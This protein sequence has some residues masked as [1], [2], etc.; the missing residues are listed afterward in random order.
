VL[1]VDEHRDSPVL[2]GL[3]DDVQADRGLARPFGAVDLDDPSPGHSPDSQG[4]VQRQRPGGDDGDPLSSG[5]LAQ[6]HHGALA[7][8]P[9]DLVQ[10][11]PEHLVA[12]HP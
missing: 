11:D 10:G 12:L 3:R 6:A 5:V 7:E 8:L 4:D 9:L 1:R 2:L